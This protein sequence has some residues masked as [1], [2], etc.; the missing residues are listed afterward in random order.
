MAAGFS[1]V[2]IGELFWCP[3]GCAFPIGFPE[4]SQPTRLGIVIGPVDDQ[5]IKSRTTR[6]PSLV[7]LYPSIPPEGFHYPQMTMN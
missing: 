3:Y 6:K 2:A 5:V 4:L 1:S 7:N